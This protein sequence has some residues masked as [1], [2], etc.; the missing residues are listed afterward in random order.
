MTEGQGQLVCAVSVRWLFAGSVTG[1]DEALRGDP[2]VARLFGLSGADWACLS[3]W[4]PP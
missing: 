3:A 1:A 4:D 2:T